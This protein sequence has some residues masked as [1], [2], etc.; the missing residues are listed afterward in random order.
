MGV[1]TQRQLSMQNPMFLG[2]TFMIVRIEKQM[3]QVIVASWS[4]GGARDVASGP[5]QHEPLRES[6]AETDQTAA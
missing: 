2:F 6:F 4:G 5:G 3:G 1:A